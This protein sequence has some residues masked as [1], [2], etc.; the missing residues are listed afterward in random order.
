MVLW[1]CR[2]DESYIKFPSRINKDTNPEEHCI[3]SDIYTLETV[4]GLQNKSL[5]TSSGILCLSITV[6]FGSFILQIHVVFIQR[7]HLL[8]RLS[9]PAL[10]HMQTLRVVFAVHHYMFQAC[11]QT[12][13]QVRSH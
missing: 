3:I 7:P 8:P 9:P 12:N 1:K 11:K 2:I 10:P 4:E 13:T 6:K 5:T